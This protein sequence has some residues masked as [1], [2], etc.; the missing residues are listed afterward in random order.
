MKTKQ[1]RL[2]EMVDIITMMVDENECMDIDIK[3]YIT[4]M[5]HTFNLKKKHI[6]L[7]EDEKFIVNEIDNRNYYITQE[8]DDP[9]I[10]VIFSL[11]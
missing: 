10:F 2:R 3:D 7:L 6:N 11:K 1:D 4:N 8:D 5:A 9:N